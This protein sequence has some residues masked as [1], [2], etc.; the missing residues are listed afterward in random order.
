MTYRNPALLG[1]ASKAP[2]C[3]VCGAHN[4][5]QVVSAHSNQQRRAL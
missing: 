1:L 2:H 5:G 4:E 3:M